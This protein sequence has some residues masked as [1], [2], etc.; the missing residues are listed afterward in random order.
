MSTEL[1]SSRAAKLMR[2]NTPPESHTTSLDADTP[3]ETPLV[4]GTA[5]RDQAHPEGSSSS[6]DEDDIVRIDGHQGPLPKASEETES[7]DCSNKPDKEGGE[8]PLEQYEPWTRLQRSSYVL[9]LVIVYA[10]LVLFAW[11][12]TC[13]VTYR[14]IASGIKHYGLTSSSDARRHDLPAISARTE[15][16]VRAAGFI[17]ST[18]TVLTIPLTSTVCSKAAVVFAQHGGWKSQ[19]LSLR[20]TMILADRG[21]TDPTVY[22]RLLSGSFK[23]HAMSF[24]VMAIF[25]NILGI[26]ALVA[27]VE[28][29]D[30]C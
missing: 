24:L 10:A 28:P 19:S 25:L 13:V 30:I 2:P 23:Q 1:R 6:I 18:V 11:I 16:W 3:K 12:I 14:P 8:R 17:R 22:A 15:R 29:G 27:T 4:P 21:W 7:D 9:L 26:S 20:Q 5:S